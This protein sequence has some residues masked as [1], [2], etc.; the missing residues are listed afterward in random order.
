MDFIDYLAC[1]HHVFVTIWEYLH[2][3]KL[4]LTSHSKY[5]LMTSPV[6][7]DGANQND[8]SRTVEQGTTLCFCHYTTTSL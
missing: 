6:G 1:S 2:Y 3:P 7:T 4:F 8:S 5:F